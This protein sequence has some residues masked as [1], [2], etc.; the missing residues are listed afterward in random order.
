MSYITRDH[1]ES[2]Y[3]NI[4][5]VAKCVFVAVFG[6]SSHSAFADG[7]KFNPLFLDPGMGNGIDISKFNGEYRAFPGEYFPDIYLNGRLIGRDKV[8]VREVNT[9]S[10]ICFTL[11]LATK[12]GFK[13]DL[14]TPEQLSVLRDP[15]ACFDLEELPS[16]KAE[17]QVSDMRLNLSI[18]QVWL[19]T[20]AR[21][22][23]DPSLWDNGTNAL[24]ASYDT[25]YF[26][27]T[28]G[29]YT[30]ESFYGS[31]R[32]G[33]NANGWMF[34]HSGALKW[35]KDQSK[36]YTVFSNNVQ[37]DITPIRSRILFGDATTSGVLFDSFSFRGVQL[38]TAEQM[39][40][41]S[42]RGYAPV[43]RGVAQ[44]N[45]RVSIHQNNTLI[46]ET[47]VPPGEFAISDLYP[48]GYG[49]DLQ[50]KV[51][52]SDGRESSFVVPYSSVSELIRPGT[53]RYGIVMGTLRHQN[54]HSTPKIFQATLQHGIN[55]W[56]TGYTGLMGTGDYYS[57][58]LGGAISTPIGA[59]ALDVTGA[60]FSD[61][62]S[63]QSGVSVRG[64][65]SKF[66]PSTDSSISIAAYRFS[67][68]GYLDLANATQLADVHKHKPIT[69]YSYLLD[70]PQ[71]RFSVTLSQYLGATYG[72]FYLS[73]FAQNYWNDKDRDVQ[74]Q[75]GYSNQFRS[76]SYGLAVNRMNNSGYS[77]TQYTLSLSFPFGSGP[78]TPY[79]N[80]YTTRSNNGVSSQLGVSGNAGEKD[81]INYNLGVSRDDESNHSGNLS[82]SYRFRD[83]L[84]KGS[85]ATGK[86]YHAYTA[87]LNGS[88]VVLPDALIASSYIG[89]TQAIVKAPGAVGAS[90]E[91]YPGVTLNGA[92][93]AIVPYLTPYRVNNVA[94]NPE[95]MPL[96]V[97][98]MMSSKQVVPRAGAIVQVNYPTQHGRVV[99]IRANLPDGEALPFGASV[100][101]DDGSEVGVVAQG[102][103]IYARLN[104]DM[105]RLQVRWGE[106][107]RYICSFNVDAAEK[108]AQR[109]S[110]FQRINT[111]CH[112]PD[113][114]EKEK[115]LALLK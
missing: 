42:Q 19:E 4:S 83:V 104:D 15:K 8:I 18:P 39:L 112:Y 65:Y 72:Q 94:I 86:N 96:D 26:N 46:Y 10:I 101:S 25:T 63:S 48:S 115:S 35:N 76:V 102:G 7:V 89:D 58:L 27:Q 12:M 55:N 64:S 3:Y 13:T 34:R 70:R 38:A 62:E 98:L 40:P 99:L 84:V 80:S 29:K 57:G 79:V 54:T 74:Y 68:S 9:R 49:G 32:G 77:E 97:E 110:Q 82:G 81:Q 109:Q 69:G 2:R 105:N 78:H 31:L 37:R 11:P 6:L 45:A 107:E 91:G 59:F 111:V 100:T 53:Y 93:Y 113:S 106:N 44:T 1:I 50:V 92:G 87:G 30:A 56:L 43:V 90:V 21:G 5:C 23:V 75:L 24:F 67:S 16:T 61:S 60:R 47:T 114:S 88:V 14:L 17:L 33:L 85:Y 66:I 52:E 20:S 71:N 28:V 41:D 22:Y 95:G 73:G 108:S 103:Q 36:S 51:T